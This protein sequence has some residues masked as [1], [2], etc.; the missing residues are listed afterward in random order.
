[1]PNKILLS[2]ESF[3]NQNPLIR[4]SGGI[5]EK[6]NRAKKQGNQADR[7][8]I[9]ENFLDEDDDNYEDGFSEPGELNL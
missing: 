1:M 6:I 3:G 9:D 4:S 5:Q 8:Q 2:G 7:D